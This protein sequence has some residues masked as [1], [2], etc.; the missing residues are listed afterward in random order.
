MWVHTGP[1]EHDAQYIQSLALGSEKVWVTKG[2]ALCKF[3]HESIGSI[4]GAK[5]SGLPLCCSNYLHADATPSLVSFSRLSMA[6]MQVLCGMNCSFLSYVQA[7]LRYGLPRRD[8]LGASGSCGHITAKSWSSPSASA[9]SVVK[10]RRLPHSGWMAGGQHSQRWESQFLEEGQNGRWTYTRYSHSSQ[11]GHG[12]A[13][14]VQSW[15]T[16]PIIQ[17]VAGT[18]CRDSGVPS[19]SAPI[20]GAT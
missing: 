4:D 10:E 3:R 8:S 18:V 1:C 15:R 16:F 19:S 6:L 17:H 14:Q 5:P 7:G 20:V 11:S 12:E 9:R 13:G 2:I